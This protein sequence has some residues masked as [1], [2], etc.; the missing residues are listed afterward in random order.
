M[1]TQK[2]AAYR[3]KM[4]D[5]N[6][7]FDVRGFL[8]KL[9]RFWPV[10]VISLSIAYGYAYYI[11]VRQLPVYY[12]EN[13]I[14]IKDDQNPFFTTNTSLTFNWGGTTDKVNTALVT[15]RSRTHAEK[16]VNELGYFVS[17]QKDGKYQR[18]DAYGSVPFEIEIDREHPQVLNQEFVL[19][20]N[21]ENA[22][23]LSGIWTDG[24]TRGAQIYDRAHTLTQVALPDGGIDRQYALG[25][26]IDLEFLNI[27]LWPNPGLQ[28]EPGATYYLRFMPFDQSV[29]GYMGVNTQPQNGSSVIKLSMVGGNK[30]RMVD[31]LNG[32]VEVLSRDML[33]RKNLFATKTIRFI[34]SSLALKSQELSLAEDQLNAFKNKSSILDLEYEGETLRTELTALDLQ[35]EALARELNYYGVLENYLLTHDDYSNTPA[36]SVIG[37]SEGS[38]V[39]GVTQ[40]IEKALERSKLEYSYQE[41]APIFRDIDRQIDAIKRV[42]QEN[43]S[44]SKALKNEEL[45]RVKRDISLKERDIKRLPKDRQELLKIERVYTLSRGTY[46]LFLSKR[47]EAGLVKAAN[48]SDVLV[49]DTAKD[50][51]GGQIGPNNQLNYTMALFFGFLIPFALVF[52]WVFVDTKIHHVGDLQRVTEIPIIGVIGT[53]KSGGNLAVLNAP[54]SPISESFRALRANLQFFYSDQKIEGAKTV[55]IT[56]SV[57]GEGKTFCAI[58]LASVFALSGKKTVLLGMDLRKPKIFGDFEIGNETGV[59]HYLSHQASLEQ[60][61]QRTQNQHLDVITAGPVPPN[62][63]EL[64]LSEG[65]AE[66]FRELKAKYDYIVID[67]APLGLVTDT[68]SL[69]AYTDATL[70]LTRQNYT[71]RG[72]LSLVNEKHRSGILPHLSIVFNYVRA[73]KALNYDY[74]YG[75]GYGYG[76]DY[77]QGYHETPSKPK[78]ILARLRRFWS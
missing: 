36:P 18:V 74:G 73:Q 26:K 55:L 1:N 7:I 54:K 56:S 53:H 48:V 57:S 49:I 52:L 66:L 76:K 15:L 13:S 51:G 21:D 8:I 43:I 20:F 29:K 34:D 30:A 47:S 5:L 17:I 9:L 35:E 3:A 4:N 65:M 11:S 44:S 12:M 72:M 46:D 75:Y 45:G 27:T 25:Q 6:A 39:T 22:F 71:K 32:S 63:S 78:G 64:M 50:T 31:Y 61:V 67:S 33:D 60:I 28:A 24:G 40:I 62:P 37:I 19:E 58:N 38:V 2:P 68:L 10:F 16:V 23:T 70:Y 14:S 69:L 59:V 77:G 42:L 41:G